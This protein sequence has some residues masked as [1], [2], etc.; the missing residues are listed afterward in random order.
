MI[1]MT[2]ICTHFALTLARPCAA[3][4]G[5]VKVYGGEDQFL[6]P[7]LAAPLAFLEL[8][9]IWEEEEEEEEEERGGHGADAGPEEWVFV[10]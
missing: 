10:E 5:G 6:P 2:M 1:E 4:H 9:N 3:G 7:A 8:Q